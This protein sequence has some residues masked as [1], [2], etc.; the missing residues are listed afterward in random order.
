MQAKGTSRLGFSTADEF[1]AADS[2][3]RNAH[4]VSAMLDPMPSPIDNPFG[5][6]AWAKVVE[7]NQNQPMM[8]IPATGMI[9]PQT[10]IEPIRPVTLGPPKFAAVVSHRSTM[11]PMQVDIGVDE[12]PGKKP[13]R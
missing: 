10:V 6:Q 11:R 3:P 13:A 8:D 12:S 9:T 1:C 2:M 7:L 4:S 5:F